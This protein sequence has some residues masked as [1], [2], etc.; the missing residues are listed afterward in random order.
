MKW[1]VICIILVAVFLGLYMRKKTIEE[2]DFIT[3]TPPRHPLSVCR[4]GTVVITDA[5]QG[6]A[7]E[8]ALLLA[9]YGLHVLAGVRTESEARSFIYDTRK[10]LEPI[11]LDLSQPVQLARLLYRIKQVTRELNR[12]LMGI[13]I[14]VADAMADS[15]P[16]AS[17]VDLEA[18]DSN[19]RAVLKGPV[20]L[21]QACISYWKET[22]NNN[23]KNNNNSND[24][25]IDSSSRSS[26]LESN[27]ASPLGDCVDVASGHV[28][29]LV[30]LSS[31]RFH[32]K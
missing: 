27:V 29:R 1:S 32:V 21:L 9:D 10:G 12:P 17:E 19:Y 23:H 8:A 20:R 14:N 24:K 6:P 15:V 18:L 16:D 26:N 3:N 30:V 4:G 13:M 5:A 31:A 22:R 11:V 25:N 2:V 7:R 28:G